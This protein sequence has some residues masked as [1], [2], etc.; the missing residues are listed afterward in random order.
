MSTDLIYAETGDRIWW[1]WK[2][3]DMR[4]AFLI[5]ETDKVVSALASRPSLE[6]DGS[7]NHLHGAL[8]LQMI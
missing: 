8:Y 5:Q 3:E 4:S 1:A 6:E 7:G 2:H